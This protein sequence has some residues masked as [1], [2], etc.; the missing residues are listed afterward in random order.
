[1]RPAAR[2]Y[3]DRDDGPNTFGMLT[4]QLEYDPAA[5]RVAA[6]DRSLQPQCVEH[7]QEIDD[8]MLG[9]VRLGVRGGVRQPLPARIHADHAVRGLQATLRVEGELG[10][11]VPTRQPDHVGPVA[12]PRAAPHR[13]AAGVITAE[14]GPTVRR[15]LR[16]A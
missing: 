8:V 9:V 3:A 16:A 1:L 14:E 7:T 6:H 5:A 4:G 2:G 13:A 15:V 12:R 10:V 11:V